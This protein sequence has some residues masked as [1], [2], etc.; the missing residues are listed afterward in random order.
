MPSVRFT[1]FIP[2]IFAHECVFAHGHGGDYRYVIPE[3]VAG[4][5][6]GVTKWGIDKSGHPNLSTEQ[7]K[8]LTL[9]QA[10]SIYY[11]EW[12][13][14]NCDHYA[15]GLAEAFFNCCVNCG[16]SRANRILAKGIHTGEAFLDEQ[17]AF[18]RRLADA[19]P[20]LEK[21]LTGWLART[22]DLRNWIAKEDK[23]K[24]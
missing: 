9:E 22:N 13:R 18:Y 6:G 1:K 16:E 10:T 14:Y 21:F 8:N 11:G 4:D 2:F 7:I 5:S 12:Q 24:A 19:R 3:N 20:S 15:A 23:E 17:E